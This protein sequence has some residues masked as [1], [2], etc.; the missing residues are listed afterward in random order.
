[1]GF[2]VIQHS[3]EHAPLVAAQAA[4]VAVDSAEGL[5]LSRQEATHAPSTVSPPFAVYLDP[6]VQATTADRSTWVLRRPI[7]TPPAP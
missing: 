6:E 4:V 1:M 5:E 7:G 2:L 3:P